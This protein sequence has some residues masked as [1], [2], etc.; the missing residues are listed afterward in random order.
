MYLTDE[1]LFLLM[2]K[3][4][5]SICIPA[6]KRTVFLRRLLQSIEMQTF[7]DFEVIVSDDSDDDS[8]F[9]LVNEFSKNINILY[10]KNE[11]AL[12]TPAN[13]NFGISKANGEWI[14]LIH[15]D[16]W[17][18][19]SESLSIFL[20]YTKSGM[21]FI[22]SAYNNYFEETKQ[23]H[24]MRF[25]EFSKRR[26]LQAPMTLIADNVI[27]PPSVIMLHSSI[28]EEYDERFK[29]RVDQEF[30]MRILAREKS[31]FYIDKALINVG[32][33][34]S[35]VT[36]T[37][38]NIPLVELPEGYL[39]L[40]KYG[41]KPLRNVLVFDTWWRMLRNM[42]I[43][44]KSNL[45]KCGQFNWPKVIIKMMIMQSHIP[46]SV[47]KQGFIS[48]LFMSISYLLNRVQSNI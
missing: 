17:F 35:Q 48:K 36:N 40:D 4:K 31:F 26:I 28:H 44:T 45:E 7:K 25:A 13:W 14:K 38:K 20:D 24:E 47:L 10:F 2:Y 11:K 12:G 18:T 41:I 30:Y 37:C 16:D 43:R 33:S 39:L 32:I 1:L 6:Y 29:W 8:V 19:S 42:D 22:F 34:A 3:C 15:D 21:K 27:G 9:Q 23:I 5:V 46:R